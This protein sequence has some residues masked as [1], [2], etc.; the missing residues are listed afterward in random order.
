M[1]QKSYTYL[2]YSFNYV[3]LG[4]TYRD[5]LYCQYIRTSK[6]IQI[7]PMFVGLY[8]FLILFTFIVTISQRIKVI[9]CKQWWRNKMCTWNGVVSDEKSVRFSI[10]FQ[11][12]SSFHHYYESFTSIKYNCDT[13]SGSGKYIV[14]AKW[15]RKQKQKGTKLV[16][17]SVSIQTYM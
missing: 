5:F 8:I 7:L 2:K 10:K 1:N 17:T 3:G 14:R 12:Q 6:L 13:L 9:I 16:A 4:H 15:S 11:I